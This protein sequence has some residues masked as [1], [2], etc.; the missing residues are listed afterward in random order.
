MKKYISIFLSLILLV[1]LMLSGCGNEKDKD[2]ADIY[3]LNLTGTSMAVEEHDKPDGAPEEQAIALLELLHSQPQESDFR[4]TIPKSVSIRDVV[5]NGYMLTVDF[6]EEYKNLSTTEEILVRAAIVRTMVQVEGISFVSFLVEGAPLTDV[7]GNYIGGMSADSFVENP[8]AQINTSLTT[9]LNLYFADET[10]TKLEKET[11]RVHY[12]S[13]ISMEKLVMEQIIDGPKKQGLQGVISPETKIIN[14]SVAEGICYVNMDSTFLI[15]NENIA[16]DVLLYSIVNSLTELPNVE[17]VQ[18]SVNGDT[19]GKVRY[20]FELG[21]MYEHN[22]SILNQGTSDS[23]ETELT[24]PEE[25][26]TPN[27]SDEIIE[28]TKK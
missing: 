28:K 18:I 16:E 8:G 27:D 26:E 1:S 10:G 22:D 14:I 12:S 25:T 19:S 24:D 5:I 2:E 17:K 6:S 20:Q 4:Q 21:T 7:N 3:Y 13:N 15:Q 9:S 11:R 23:T